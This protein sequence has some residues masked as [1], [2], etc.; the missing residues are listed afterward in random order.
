MRRRLLVIAFV[1]GIGLIAAPAIFQMFSRAPKG[2]RMMD[3]FRPYMTTAQV[4]KY[5][6]YMAEIDAPPTPS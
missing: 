5:Q 3:N 1:L 4:N 6:S 2:G